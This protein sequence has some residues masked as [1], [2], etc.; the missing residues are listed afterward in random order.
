MSK[1]GG[2]IGSN[3]YGPHGIGKASGTRRPFGE[4]ATTLGDDTPS[5]NSSRQEKPAL[6]RQYNQL[7][8]AYSNV[9]GMPEVI[10]QK[11][12]ALSDYTRHVAWMERK[13]PIWRLEYD[14]R[15]FAEEWSRQD[16]IRSQKH[17]R[18]IS[19]TKKLVDLAVAKGLSPMFTGDINDRGDV[20]EFA[21]VFGEQLYTANKT[22]SGSSNSR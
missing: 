11:V 22:K 17:E 1:T 6:V 12:A 3:Q 10:D 15:G 20:A 5:N 13:A 7:V 16:T 8:Q 14:P 19:A 18:A 21:G 9:A 4:P 2:G